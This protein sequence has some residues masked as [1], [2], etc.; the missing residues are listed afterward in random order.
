MNSINK[1]LLPVILVTS[2]VFVHGENGQLR[3]FLSVN[4]SPRFETIVDFLH[5]H[6]HDPTWC[7]MVSLKLE[8]A[9]INQTTPRD[10]R[11]IS[12]IFITIINQTDQ[13]KTSDDIRWLDLLGSPFKDLVLNSGIAKGIPGKLNGTLGDK[14]S[15]ELKL[16]RESSCSTIDWLTVMNIINAY[17]QQLQEAAKTESF[18]ACCKNLGA[19]LKTVLETP[20][21]DKLLSITFDD[22]EGHSLYLTFGYK[23]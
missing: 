1:L 16:E 21:I 19:P 15:L 13:A 12:G 9:K 11:M 4:P 10:W 6:R 23:N 8:I 3:N 17:I 2:P 7:K 22:K 14:I 20:N 5:E 18:L